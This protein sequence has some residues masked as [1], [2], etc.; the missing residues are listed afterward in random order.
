MPID[1]ACAVVSQL[2][3]WQDVAPSFG[4]FIKEQASTA[5]EPTKILELVRKR[6]PGIVITQE[7]GVS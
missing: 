6:R 3:M 2:V 4:I 1:L 5:P 7:R